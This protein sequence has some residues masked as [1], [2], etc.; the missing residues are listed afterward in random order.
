MKELRGRIVRELGDCATASCGTLA[1]RIIDVLR[2]WI[3][4]PEV[5]V[6]AAYPIYVGCTLKP[7]TSPATPEHKAPT[8]LTQEQSINLARKALELALT[9]ETVAKA[10]HDTP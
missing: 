1:D 3:A 7:W 9:A 10:E 5:Q 2:D 6:R 4:E 8:A